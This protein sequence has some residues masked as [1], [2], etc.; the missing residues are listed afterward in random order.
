MLA[1]RIDRRLGHADAVI[2][3]QDETGIPVPADRDRQGPLAAPFKT[4]DDSIGNELVQDQRQRRRSIGRQ[5][6]YFPGKF[7]LYMAVLA[8]QAVSQEAQQFLGHVGNINVLFIVVG[9]RLVDQ[10]NAENPVQA[11]FE[12]VPRFF[13]GRAPHLHAQQTGDGLQ[14]VLDAVVD[15]LD[16]RRLDHEF[17]FLAVQFC[18]LGQDGNDPADFAALQ[19]RNDPAGNDGF[20]E[21]HV[22]GQPRRLGQGFLGPGQVEAGI[23]DIGP[24]NGAALAAHVQDAVGHVVGIDDDAVAVDQDDAILDGQGPVHG[25]EIHGHL[26]GQKGRFRQDFPIVFDGSDKGNDGNRPAAV[27]DEGIG[28]DRRHAAVFDFPFALQGLPGLED[29][30]VEGFFIPGKDSA[31]IGRLGLPS[32]LQ[33]RRPVGGQDQGPRVFSRHVDEEFPVR[34]V[35]GEL[36]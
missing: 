20:T 33:E 16:D 12:D 30:I 9:Q 7:R 34:Q 32:F 22:V 23:V 31:R 14:V 13:T 25:M 1:A 3:D 18:P 8:D 2:T 26:Q 15:F 36:Q 35:A 29:L 21:R 5:R 10:R 17:F 4:V 11:F 6:Q 24:R 27:I 19:D 28:H